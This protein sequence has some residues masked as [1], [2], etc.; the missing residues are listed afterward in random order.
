M[1]YFCVVMLALD[2]STYIPQ[3]FVFGIL[4][5]RNMLDFLPSFHYLLS[6]SLLDVLRMEG[7]V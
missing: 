2:F 5:A 6:C 7:R 3:D 4:R 1:D